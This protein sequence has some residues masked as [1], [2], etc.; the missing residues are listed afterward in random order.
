MIPWKLIDQAVVPGSQSELRLYQRDREFSIRVDGHE[1]M[2]SRV[3][4][5]EDAFSEL[6]CARVRHLAEPHV[7]IGGLGL[8]YS[9]RSALAHLPERARVSVVELVPQVAAWNRDVLGHLAGHPLDDARVT[10]LVSDV[11]KV[12]RDAHDEYD[13]IMLDVDNGPRALTRKSNEW[14]YTRAGLAA[15]RAAL[16]PKGILGFW[17]SGPDEP[18]VKR[19]RDMGFDVEERTLKAADRVYG[20]MHTIWL[21]TEARSA[22]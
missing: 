15:A 22:G 3:Y 11:G 9:L 2:S 1:L 10:L 18:F 21:A 6:G 16:R 12:L 19:L 14:L 7:L 13:L 5:S 4:A 8:G 20:V 17:S